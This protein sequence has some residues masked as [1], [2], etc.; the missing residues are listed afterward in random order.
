[1]TTVRTKEPKRAEN[2]INLQN[3][4]RKNLKQRVKLA[5][6][7]G[8]LTTAGLL[9]SQQSK[10][11]EINKNNT[12]FTPQ[13][14]TTVQNVP[15]LQIL[16]VESEVLGRTSNKREEVKQRYEKYVSSL[17][18]D[19]SNHFGFGNITEVGSERSQ[20][21]AEAIR[22]LDEKELFL[23]LSQTFHKTSK[24]TGSKLT[25]ISTALDT[26]VYNCHSTTTILADVLERLG[27]PV[28]IIYVY[29]PDHV[30]LIGKDYALDATQ[31][32]NDDIVFT[33]E[34]AYNKYNLMKETDVGK[35][36]VGTYELK[37]YKLIKEGKLDQALEAYN[38]GLKIDQ[39]DINSLFGKRDVLEKMGREK[40]AEECTNKIISIKSVA[41]IDNFIIMASREVE[42]DPK[43]ADLWVNLGKTY[44]GSKRMENAITAYNS[45]IELDPKSTNSWLAKAALLHKT[46]NDVEAVKVLDAAVKENFED[47]NKV[48]VL[49]SLKE[50]IL[51]DKN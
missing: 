10:A 5:L 27:K 48:L 9:G 38:Q 23:Y 51:S 37:G 46:G 20:K 7:V 16:K 3:P 8:T 1:M 41:V 14:V 28:G 40:E 25:F 29:D 17:M 33:R 45:A 32:R 22:K 26:K 35:L 15:I 47:K 21:I 50:Q 13:Q 39:N 6:A 11:Q 49:Q 2:K 4:K 34:D 19:L 42:K 12:N 43:N 18:N 36:L 30:F 31:K 44:E 24:S